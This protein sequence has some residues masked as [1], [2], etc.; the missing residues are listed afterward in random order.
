MPQVA[1]ESRQ[2]VDVPTAVILHDETVVALTPGT[3]LGLALPIR[4]D[5]VTPARATR[6]FGEPCPRRHIARLLGDKSQQD[7]AFFLIVPLSPHQ[8]GTNSQN[9]EWQEP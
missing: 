6:E 9:L 5:V 4:A 3:R 1:G 2:F 7:S 8:P